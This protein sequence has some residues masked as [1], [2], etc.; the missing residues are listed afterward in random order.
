M[1]TRY[2]AWIVIVAIAALT[3]ILAACG[4][5]PPPTGDDP[6]PP[7]S[8]EDPPPLTLSSVTTVSG[9]LYVYDLSG[10]NIR[11]DATVFVC[12][13]QASESEVRDA[14]DDVITDASRTGVLI[15]FR[16]P[17]LGPVQLDCD[18]RVEQPLGDD[19]ETATLEDALTYMPPLTLERLEAVPDTNRPDYKLFGTN[20]RGNADV[21]VCEQRAL[22]PV[23]RDADDEIV[24]PSSRAGVVVRFRVPDL[25]PDSKACEVR[26]EQRLGDALEVVVLSDTLAYARWEPL[27]G[28]RVLVY[29]SIFSGDGEQNP[30]ARFDAAM[31]SVEDDVG[32]NLTFVDGTFEQYVEGDVARDFRD[33]LIA[34]EW[35]AVVFIEEQWD[36]PSDV[37]EAIS[38]YVSEDF[39]RALSSYWLAFEDSPRGTRARTFAASFGAVATP[40][41]N[42]TPVEGGRVDIAFAG[43]LAQGLSS[44]QHE[45]VNDGFYVL[46]YAIRLEPASGAVSLCAYVDTTGGSCAVGKEDSTSL[47]LGFTLAPLSVSMSG[48]DLEALFENALRYVILDDDD[49]APL[50]AN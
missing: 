2:G 13:V 22:L 24:S 9:E 8:E 26:V 3:L 28:T 6:P 23:V 34:D 36:L 15:R 5:Q 43:S 46:S 37:L 47:Y 25:G 7:P 20:I 44:A 16:V 17:D 27:A 12:D 29:A 10:E 40:E 32:L 35:D 11:G 45:L 49:A 39:G 38:L 19:V 42:V 41:D 48:S 1:R 33:L 30:R 31:L 4:T 21:F 50:G 14:D 18:V